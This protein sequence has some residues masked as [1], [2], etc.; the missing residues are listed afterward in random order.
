M[1]DV[2]TTETPAVSAAVSYKQGNHSLFLCAASSLR[3][4]G[5]TGDTGDGE[6]PA[7]PRAHSSPRSANNLKVLDTSITPPPPEEDYTDATKTA[8]NSTH[9]PD[10][11]KAEH[12][13]ETQA[14]VGE[15]HELT[16]HLRK[17]GAR[18]ATLTRRRTWGVTFLTGASVSQ[19][20][21]P[22]ITQAC[23]LNARHRIIDHAPENL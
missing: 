6:R 21:C 11:R 15:P 17:P 18:E 9:T 12:A 10:A 20:G 7:V 19:V 8:Q 5:R 23:M 14:F 22:G 4:R 1:R 16:S 13:R 2:C 3:Q